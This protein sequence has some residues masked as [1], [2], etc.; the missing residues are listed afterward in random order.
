MLRVEFNDDEISDEEL[1]GLPTSQ[2]KDLYKLFLDIVDTKEY[3]I[4][5]C[6]E[7]FKPG[8][9]SFTNFLLL[10][11]YKTSWFDYTQVE[12][13]VLDIDCYIDMLREDESEFYED[14]DDFE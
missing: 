11:E 14:E 7:Y 9:D 5:E 6:M 4:E 13:I 3:S 8:T 1:F 10:L 2:E 12:D